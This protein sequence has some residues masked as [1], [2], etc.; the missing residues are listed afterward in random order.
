MPNRHQEVLWLASGLNVEVTGIERFALDLLDLLL[1]RGV[2]AADDLQI[3]A[4]AG[5][6][7][8][9]HAAAKGV[10]VRRHTGPPFVAPGQFDGESFKLIHNFGHAIFPR[11]ISGLRLLTVC[12]WGPFEDRTMSWRARASWV[13][14]LARASI[15]ADSVHYL[16][17][18]LEKTRPR[19]FRRAQSSFVAY[20]DAL[21]L[22]SGLDLS[23]SC[24][25]PLF[26]GTADGRKR[27]HEVAAFAEATR[28]HVTLMGRGTERY[29]S[30]WVDAHGRV[31]EAELDEGYASA[32]ALIL[33][34]TYEGF[35][36]PILEA[37]R[38]GI[39]SVVSFEV[40]A[41]LPHS[42]RLFCRPVDPHDACAFRAALDEA[43]AARGSARFTGNLLDPMI[44]AYGERLAA[45]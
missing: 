14:S 7:W 25:K 34:S 31:T 20:P 45:P 12:D 29:A 35:G 37:A 10:R 36:L 43:E 17:A 30:D 16:N 9:E 3:I 18:E 21:M 38:R 39:F 28:S 13:Q 1:H 23:M 42:L 27:L 22:G 40:A 15:A 26:V 44:A 19:L 24:G 2:I 8:V 6:T 41:V 33:V 11:R 5:A 4:D 32:S